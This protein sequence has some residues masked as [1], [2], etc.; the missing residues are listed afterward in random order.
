MGVR[1]RTLVPVRSSR[2]RRHCRDRIHH[3]PRVR[4][5]TPT[6]IHIRLIL[7]RALGLR[8]CRLARRI[9]G[10]ASLIN[11]RLLPVRPASTLRRSHRRT[12]GRLHRACCKPAAGALVEVLGMEQRWDH[13]RAVGLCTLLRASRI[14]E[15]STARPHLGCAPTS[16]PLSCPLGGGRQPCHQA[17]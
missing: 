7:I 5:N 9:L 6:R 1:R 13:R 4:R 17:S 11:G 10:C 12:P 14:C 2:P 8:R 16:A 3:C 15:G